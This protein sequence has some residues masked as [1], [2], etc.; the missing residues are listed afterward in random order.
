[1]LDLCSYLQLDLHWDGLRYLGVS[2]LAWQCD[3]IVGLLVLGEGERDV[4]G[5][6]VKDDSDGDVE[7]AQQYHHLA[8]PVEDVK[9]DVWVSG[10]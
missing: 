6:K 3:I 8:G 1:M 10:H 2:D 4:Q 5:A 7:E 9:S